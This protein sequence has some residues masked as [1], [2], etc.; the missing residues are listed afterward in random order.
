MHSQLSAVPLLV[1]TI[2]RY[3]RGPSEL[4][5][6]GFLHAFGL[7]MTHATT[8][9]DYASAVCSAERACQCHGSDMIYYAREQNNNNIA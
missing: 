6:R 1:T 9:I 8:L 2:S 3:P 7:N 4:R 5:V